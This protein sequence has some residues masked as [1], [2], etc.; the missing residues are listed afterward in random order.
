MKQLIAI[1]LALVLTCGLCACGR[2]NDIPE[3][4]TTIPTTTAP[5]VVTTA[6]TTEP[7]M[8]TVLPDPTLDTNV[9]DPSI[10]TGETETTEILPGEEDLTEE[11]TVESR[12]GGKMS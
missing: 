11:E 3:P 2:K 7:T 5:T 12:R 4:S 1:A 6:P 8:G 9:P 10:E